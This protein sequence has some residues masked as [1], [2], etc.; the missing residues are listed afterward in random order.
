MPAVATDILRVEDL[1]RSE[2]NAHDAFEP[3][4]G[5]V[6]RHQAVSQQGGFLQQQAFP[7]P[8]GVDAVARLE[9]GL[10]RMLACFAVADVV[11][12]GGQA[13]GYPGNA[14]F[15]EEHRRL[16]A[17]VNQRGRVLEPKRLA[18]PFG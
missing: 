6:F 7:N 2:R 4:R 14:G 12:A 8:A 16:F 18:Q 13:A 3:A 15:S 1:I 10:Y 11:R 5:D 9:A 17:E